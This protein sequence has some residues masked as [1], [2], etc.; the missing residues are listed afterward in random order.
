MGAPHGLEEGCGKT[1]S[2]SYQ[3]LPQFL[4][5]GTSLL[6]AGTPCWMH[7]TQASSGLF[8][9]MP[10]LPLLCL[11]PASVPEQLPFGGA[12]LVASN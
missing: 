11:L 2:T 8:L 7:H 3:G 12:E 1:T 9:L 10:S 5:L 4:S 6:S